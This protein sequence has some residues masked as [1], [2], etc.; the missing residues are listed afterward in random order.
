[1]RRSILVV[2]ASITLAVGGVLV[3]SPASANPSAHAICWGCANPPPPVL[4]VQRALNLHYGAHT[5]VEDG[6]FQRA[7]DG[8]VRRLQTDAHLSVDG[9]VG[10]D[11]GQ[12]IW[13]EL[14]RHNQHPECYALVPTHT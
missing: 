13:N 4:C 8:V 6:S 5:L 10:R 12:L 2:W 14:V 11:T 3:A 1:M 9:V 7:T